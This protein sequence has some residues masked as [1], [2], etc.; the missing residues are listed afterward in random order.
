MTNKTIKP[1]FK[2]IGGKS[3]LR[4]ELRE[5]VE[6]LLSKNKFKY[7]AE[8]FAGG[9]GSFLNVYD[10]LIKANIEKVYISD[11]NNILIETYKHIKNN[12]QSLIDE[13][14]SLELSFDAV[15][16]KDWRSETDKDKLK[17]ILKPSEVFFNDVKKTFNS[18]KALGS[19]N[20]RQSVRLVFLQKHS[21][22]GIYRENSKG[23]YNTPFNWSGS[24]MIDTIQEKVYELSDIFNKLNVV[25]STNSVENIEFNRKTLYYLDPPYINEES[26]E[27]KYNKEVFD[28]TKQ[29]ALIN[30]IKDTSFIYSNHQSEVLQKEFDKMDNLK[31]LEIVRNNIMSAKAETR[32]NGKI[33]ILV[34]HEQL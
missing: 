20:L 33:E 19:Q 22:N 9:L 15:T 28:V 4:D 11:I 31:L 3:W 18:E 6:L 24:N 29:I 26:S 23:F 27:N 1:L 2:Y 32:K 14:I 8:P 25:F 17:E 21:F 16:P 10:I 34:T 7:Y 13:Y 30:K 5:S 12:P